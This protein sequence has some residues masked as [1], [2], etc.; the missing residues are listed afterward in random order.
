[1]HQPQPTTNF[2]KVEKIEEKKFQRPPVPTFS[3]VHKHIEDRVYDQHIVPQAPVTHIVKEV[4]YEDTHHYNKQ[5]EKKTDEQHHEYQRII[6]PTWVQKQSDRLIYE[7]YYRQ[8]VTPQEY[9]RNLTRSEEERFYEYYDRQGGTTLNEIKEDLKQQIIYPS[10]LVSTEEKKIFEEFYLSRV[11]VVGHARNLTTYELEEFEDYYREQLAKEIQEK[12]QVYKAKHYNLHYPNWVVTETDKKI[13]E[14]YYFSHVAESEYG[15]ELT[16]D[17]RVEFEVYYSEN[18]GATGHV[19]ES[20]DHAGYR[21]VYPD[22][23][24]TTED[25]AIYEEYYKEVVGENYGRELTEH[26]LHEF[27]EYY[28]THGGTTKHDTI[29][30]LSQ[31][32]Y[33]INY[34]SWIVTQVDKV[35][36]EEFYRIHVRIEEYGRELTTEEL[37]QFEEYYKQRGGSSRK[38]LDE[39]LFMRL[40]YPSWL[41][42]EYDRSMYRE[43]Y[44][45]QVYVEDYGRFLTDEESAQFVEYYD[46]HTKGQYE[47]LRGQIDYQWVYPSFVVTRT[48]R[49]I[50]NAY[51]NQCMA[52][53]LDLGRQLTESEKIEFQQW[54]IE[55]GK[56]GLTGI[57]G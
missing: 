50:F 29:E 43:F 19:V 45:R 14:E 39:T 51:Y 16:K 27:E 28:R 26:E 8:C 55:K 57:T 11:G 47:T 21:I 7:E 37:L 49:R 12:E 3:T 30:D 22:W 18:G 32:S 34:P 40:S 56:R 38:V 24:V 4:E 31:L 15:R 25:R 48:D 33:K 9:G 52:S 44:L 10:Y 2:K 17:E 1:M 36:F 5:Y 23:V 20:Y 46:R 54:F 6:F 13:F 42:T 35:I 41:H 53:K